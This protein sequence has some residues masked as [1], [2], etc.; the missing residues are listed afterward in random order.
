[1]CINESTFRRE[2]KWTLSDPKLN[3][4]FSSCTFYSFSYSFL[5]FKPLT[6]TKGFTFTC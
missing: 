5:F 6:P 4:S 2:T 1:M 3:M